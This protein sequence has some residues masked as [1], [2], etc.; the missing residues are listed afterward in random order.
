M[1]EMKLW[2]KIGTRSEVYVSE[3][4]EVF[5]KSEVRDLYAYGALM[6]QSTMVIDS[7]INYTF[8]YDTGAV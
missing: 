1:T 6:V 7:K 4:G 3:D 2:Q 8:T 5:E